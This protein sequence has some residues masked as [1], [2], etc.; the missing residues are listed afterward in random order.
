M[1]GEPGKALPDNWND[2]PGARCFPPKICAFCEKLDALATVVYLS[3]QQQPALQAAAC[4][5]A[6]PYKLLSDGQLLFA[7]ALNLPKF[8]I[9][10]QRYIKR[11]TMICRNDVIEKVFYPVLPPDKNAQQ[12]INYLKKSG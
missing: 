10:N 5:L 11:M 1:L 8:T 9:D 6:L 7:D 2:I 3:R 12:V 4:R